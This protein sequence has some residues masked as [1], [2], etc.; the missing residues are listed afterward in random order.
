MLIAQKPDLGMYLTDTRGKTLY[1]F[2][3]DSTGSSACS[4]PCLGLWPA[5]NADP[6]TAPSALPLTDFSTV[7]RA[8]G[9]KQI[10]FKGM[11]LYYYASDVNPG[12]ARGEK[13]NFVWFA[14]NV[15]GVTVIPT[16]QTLSPSYGS[17]Y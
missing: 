4:G 7:S 12:D 6:V 17:G 13:Y 16:L 9:V 10:A 3:K 11:P 2:T 15:S 8:D 14:A 1:V 5:F